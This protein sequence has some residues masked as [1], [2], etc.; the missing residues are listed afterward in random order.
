MIRRHYTAMEIRFIRSCVS[1]NI[2]IENIAKAMNRTIGSIDNKIRRLNIFYPDKKE[3]KER[4]EKV[5]N[6]QMA[7]RALKE[8]CT[9]EISDENYYFRT[10]NVCLG[11]KWKEALKY[12]RAKIEDRGGNS[13]FI[14]GGKPMT[15]FQIMK[16][17]DASLNQY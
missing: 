13:V 15:I 5:K 6:H 17:Y 7:R 14:V 2:P 9:E 3:D 16:I 4:M 1:A 12:T 11:E 10:T 8:M